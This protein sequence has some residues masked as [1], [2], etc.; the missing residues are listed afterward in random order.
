MDSD[1]PGNQAYN[2]YSRLV[3]FS[4]FFVK[5]SQAT[6]DSGKEMGKLL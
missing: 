2:Y 6:S 3:G 1:E 4:R 5:H